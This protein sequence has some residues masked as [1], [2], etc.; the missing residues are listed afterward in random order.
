MTSVNSALESLKCTTGSSKMAF[1]EVTCGMSTV[2]TGKQVQARFV[3][4]T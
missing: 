1:K 2:F 4:L 3:L